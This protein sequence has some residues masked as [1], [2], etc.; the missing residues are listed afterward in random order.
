MTGFGK[1]LVRNF[2]VKIEFAMY[3]VSTTLDL[4]IYL[5]PSV[6]PIAHLVVAIEHLLYDHAR[7]IEIVKLRPKGIATYVRGISVYYTY[8]RL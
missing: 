5:C 7:T 3:F 4:T 8:T 2:F 6:S 1:T